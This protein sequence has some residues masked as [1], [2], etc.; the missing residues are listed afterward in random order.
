VAGENYPLPLSDFTPMIFF[1]VFVCFHPSFSRF[2]IAI[3]D[4]SF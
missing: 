2:Q 4:N 3:F 1:S